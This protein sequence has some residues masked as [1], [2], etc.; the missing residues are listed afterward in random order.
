[1]MIEIYEEHDFKMCTSNVGLD[2]TFITYD[3]TKRKHYILHDLR[4][5]NSNK[6]KALIRTKEI[7]NNLI[8]H[9]FFSL[10][11]LMFYIKK[12]ALKTI[13]IVDVSLIIVV[14]L[15]GYTALIEIKLVFS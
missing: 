2:A 14:G 8:C 1:M 3:W 5:F 9:Q 13:N 15:K 11:V 6:L 12:K 4:N 7:S 10:C